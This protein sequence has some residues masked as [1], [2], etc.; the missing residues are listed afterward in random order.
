[1]RLQQHVGRYHFAFQLGM[2]ALLPR[3]LVAAHVEPGPAV[4]PA[5]L[6][7]RDV[8]RHQVIAQ[9]VAFIYRGPQFACSGIHRDTHRIANA[10]RIHPRSAAIRIEL[11]NIGAMEFLRIVIRI[12]V[13]G[14]RADGYKHFAAIA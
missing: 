8:I 6:N 14:M 4:K 7:V 3:I 12:V 10:I 1:M 2:L 5:R 11:Q 13:V 9:P